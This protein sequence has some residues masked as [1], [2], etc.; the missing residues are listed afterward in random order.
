VWVK[1][2]GADIHVTS[3]TGGL[4]LFSVS[5]A[6]MLSGAPR[7]VYAETMAGEINLNNATTSSA[8]LKTA[9]G[10]IKVNG[11]VTDLTAVTVS[12]AIN[13]SMLNFGRARLESVDGPVRFYGA[14][15]SGSVM[16]VI[17]HA[18]SIT[19]VIPPQTSA[20]FAFNL[21]EAELTDEFGIRKRWMMS[22]KFKAKEMTFG[23]GDRPSARVTIRSFKGPVSIRRLDATK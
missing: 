3:V 5:G 11:E 2:T 19:L 1:T 18:G 7:E 8:R 4:D 23:L 20:D 13:T 16:D 17:N 12:G 22:T 9:S 15:P 6:I 10:T 14:I 21:Y